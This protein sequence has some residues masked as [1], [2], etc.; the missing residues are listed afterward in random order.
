MEN[1]LN[2]V[3]TDVFSNR[4]FGGNQL[5]VFPFADTLADWVMPAI[6]RELKLNETVFVTGKTPDGYKIRIFSPHGELPFAGHPIVGAASVLAKQFPLVDGECNF[7]LHVPAGPVPVEVSGQSKQQNI[8]IESP[9]LPTRLQQEVPASD[10]AAM[11]S[12]SEKKV[13]VDPTIAQAFSSGI[14]F[15]CVPL[16]DQNAVQ[17]A[18]LD[19]SVWSILLKDKPAPHLYIFSYGRAGEIHA[20]MFAPG[21]GIDEDPATGAAAVALG[22]YLAANARGQGDQIK[23]KIHQGMEM[24]RPSQILLDV[25]LKDRLLQSVKLGGRCFEYGRGSFSSE[26]VHTVKETMAKLDMGGGN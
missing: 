2:F 5:A 23:F 12:L 10:I 9:M 22:G 25:S 20:R 1:A 15:F 14:P 19:K 11:L 4:P 7:V 3:L 6:A 21:I 24:G 13:L 18:K 17:S 26:A 8:M 16:V